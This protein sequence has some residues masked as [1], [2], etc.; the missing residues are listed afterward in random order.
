MVD[1]GHPSNDVDNELVLFIYSPQTIIF[2]RIIIPPPERSMHGIRLLSWASMFFFVLLMLFT[3]A[4][5]SG[6]GDLPIGAGEGP[7]TDSTW[8]PN[9]PTDVGATFPSA[10]LISSVTPGDAQVTLVWVAALNHG[11]PITNYKVYRGTT[12]GSGTLV[13][14]LGDVLTY[15]DPGLVNGVTYYYRVCAVNGI[16]EGTLSNEVSATPSTVPSAPILTSATPGDAE[17]T[18]VWTA[19]PDGGASITGYRV[20]RG[21]ASGAESLLLDLGDVLAYIDADCINGVRYYYQVSA[22]NA[23]GEGQRSNERDAEP[24][25]LPSTPQNLQTTPGDAYINLTWEAPSSD[26]GSAII[27]YEVWRGAT[28]G[29]ESFLIDAGLGLWFNDTGLT[30]GQTYYYIVKANNAMGPGPNSSEANA[31][32]SPVVTLPSEPEDLVATPSDGL[33]L[34][35]WSAPTNNGGVA[36]TNYTIYRGLTPGGET[37]LAI[38]GDLLSY[39]DTDCTNGQIYFYK[40]GSVNSVGEG[41]RSE[42]VS[43]IPARAPS[44][45]TSLAS[46]VAGDGRIVITWLA[47]AD[48]G[49]PI[50]N[51]RIYRGTAS[52]GEVLLTTVG[53]VQTFDD[54]GLDIGTTYYYVVSA[55]NSM[56]EGAASIEV[57]ISPS[58]VPSVP[59]ELS[60]VAGDTV[61][62]LSWTAPAYVGS[63]ALTY[64]LIRDGSEI[65]SGTDMNYHDTN[66]DNGV[67]YSYQVSAQNSIGWGANC[68]AIMVTP[69]SGDSVPTAPLGLTANPRDALV[70]LSWAPPSYVGPGP[71]TYHLFRDG[72][73]IWSGTAL[74][75]SDDTVT[76]GVTYSYTVAAENMIG[77]GPNSTVESATPMA[78]DTAPSTP[79]GLSATADNELVELFWAPPTYTGPGALTY[80]LFRD[81]TEI[82]TGNSTTYVDYMLTKGVQ[83]TYTVTAQNSIG[84]GP[85]STAVLATPFGVPDEPW[86]LKVVVGAGRSSLS[87]NEVNYSGP[88]ALLYHL[89]R[90]GVEIWSGPNAS[91][92]DAGLVNGQKYVY[93]VAAS[94]SVGWGA[95]SSSN[96]GT[97]QGPPSIPSGLNALSGDG[98]VLL[99]WNMPDYIGPGAVSYH[100][101]RDGI[102]YWSGAS[103]SFNDTVV[104]NGIGY[105]YSVVAENDVGWG[106]NSSLVEAT[107]NNMAPVLPGQPT[108]LE[109]EASDGRVT[110][111][112][113]APSPSSDAPI[114]G[115]N[116]YR[117]VLNGEYTLIATV[118]GTSYIDHDVTNGHEYQYV[119]SAMSATGEGVM[120]AAVIIMPESI[121]LGVVDAVGMVLF[122]LAMALLSITVIMVMLVHRD[123]KGQ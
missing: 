22:V 38:I 65:W 74:G 7:F 82:W 64:H 20:F 79:L 91:H 19:P 87:W 12:S 119:V 8:Y 46:A 45:P 49:A 95:N 53:D 2:G 17:V 31:V 3:F 58:T 111:S 37:L 54:A 101:F 30:N 110:L 44:A 35:A 80:H 40:V 94:N 61:A 67:T 39:T 77:L 11:S 90:D 68:T 70:D 99:N 29:A 62:D 33:V 120:T 73:L 85:N 83:H 108:N 75:C 84:W 72:A 106:L 51:Y 55:I 57:S 28:S 43:A 48:G 69:M 96:D 47:P 15:S 36:I 4:Q 102:L 60:A 14:T 103:P 42:E 66:L 59:R 97:P 50:T 98:F 76:N 115:Y 89:F 10:P 100:L 24:I 6:T 105:A 107:P 86:G 25:G 113:E 18:L 92:D 16:G 13:A 78:G 104:V 123:R 41:P 5:T 116:V 9:A 52:G 1:K 93:N 63:G 88:G 71:L 56:G 21:T 26:G 81:G 34:L 121:Y 112:W 122:I 109:V 114:D 27:G 118:T 117:R 32:P 23:I